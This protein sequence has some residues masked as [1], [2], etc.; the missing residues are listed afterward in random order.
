MAKL[1][2]IPAAAALLGALLPAAWAAGLP[3]KAPEY[4]VNMGGGKTLLLSQYKGHPVVMAFILTYCSHCQKT[5]GF[6]SKAQND[7]GVRGLQVVASAI[8]R[9]GVAA[10]LPNFLK[11]FQPPFPVGYSEGQSALEFMQH[12]AEKMPMMPMLAFIDRQGMIRA[13]FEGDDPF[14]GDQAEQNLR[15]QIEALLKAGGPAKKAAAHP[16]AGL[17]SPFHG[18]AGNPARAGAALGAL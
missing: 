8:D 11:N 3:R 15:Q 18:P 17:R 9:E 16:A 14:F 10:A 4:T 1:R 5:V 6:L 12:P 13:E 7:Y 2:F